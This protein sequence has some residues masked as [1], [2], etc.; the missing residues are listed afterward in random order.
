PAE[1]LVRADERVAAERD[2]VPRDPSGGEGPAL[3]ELEQRAQVERAA[4]DK[5][6]VERLRARRVP[7]ARA[8]ESPVARVERVERVVEA[9]RRRRLARAVLPRDD[10]ELEREDLLRRELALDAHA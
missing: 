9:A 3:M 6:L 4:R 10:G 7:R 1:R 2:R 5:A 8:K